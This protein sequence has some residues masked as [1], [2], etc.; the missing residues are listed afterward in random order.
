MRSSV[1][2][3]RKARS[4]NVWAAGRSPL[5]EAKRTMLYRLFEKQK[6]TNSCGPAALALLL[7]RYGVGI[8]EEVLIQRLG[9]KLGEAGTSLADLR[10]LCH[11]LQVDAV[12]VEVP[13]ESLDRLPTPCVAYLRMGHF[14][15]IE[16]VD[17]PYVQLVDPAVGSLKLHMHEFSR[18]WRGIA[19]VIR[20]RKIMVPPVAEAN[21]VAQAPAGQTNFRRMLHLLLP[22]WPWIGAV[23]LLLLLN[24]GI[25]VAL[26]VSLMYF[27][28][29]IVQSASASSLGPM[30][31]VLG[32]MMVAQ[33]ALRLVSGLAYN[34]V[35]NGILYDM[36]YSL[37]KKIQRLELENIAKMNSGDLMAR[38]MN[39]TAFVQ[40]FL[41]NFS[42]GLFLNALS[43]LVLLVVAIAMNPF[44]ALVG[45]SP[46]PLFALVFWWI[47]RV[48][49]SRSRRL[50]ETN[51]AVVGQAQRTLSG[52]ESIKAYGREDLELSLFGNRLVQN[53]RAAFSIEVIQQ[54]AGAVTVL[55]GSIGPTSSRRWRSQNLDGR[56]PVS[57]ATSG[58]SRSR[59]TMVAGTCLTTSRSPFRPGARSPWSARTGA[60]SPP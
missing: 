2:A 25:S 13:L 34:M 15:V 22:Y 40:T 6:L 29:S 44:L 37:M 50:H 16:K 17:L 20:G 11:S 24:A 31:G 51:A 39:D 12:S 23:G 19:L 41:T 28:D 14:V 1:T 27:I 52:L 43:I 47:F 45:L 32:G 36:R 10:Q 58:S 9:D 26:P 21:L 59:S 57:E 46:L 3:G 54:S 7:R 56:F 53:W 33:A 8:S 48:L 49:Q 35:A 30:V 55:L 5:L 4:K 18:V 42:F 60:V 38:L